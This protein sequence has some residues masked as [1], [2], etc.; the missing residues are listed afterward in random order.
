MSTRA[1]RNPAPKRFAK[2]AV[3]TWGSCY[4]HKLK[5]THGPFPPFTCPPSSPKTHTQ[6]LLHVAACQRAHVAA[7]DALRE[8][9]RAAINGKG[10]PGADKLRRLTHH[11]LQVRQAPCARRPIHAHALSY[12]PMNCKH[13]ASQGV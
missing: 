6:V 1:K 7:Q 10:L 9:I 13:W 12:P 4:I 2:V 11:E 3:F 5:L 8:A